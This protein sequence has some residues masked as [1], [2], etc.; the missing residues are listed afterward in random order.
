MHGV[1]LVAR[2]GPG[3]AQFLERAAEAL[4]VR[5]VVDELA[6]DH[7]A[8]FVDPVGEQEAAV[9]YRDFPFGFREI[10]AIHEDGADH[11]RR[12]L[13][14]CTASKHDSGRQIHGGCGRLAGR[15]GEWPTSTARQDIMPRN[16]PEQAIKAMLSR[17]EALF[18]QRNPISKK[19]SEDAARNWLKGVP[20]HW[21]VDWGTPVP[22]VH[23]QGA[24]RRRDRRRRPPLHRLLPGRHRRHV[25][26]FAARRGR[27]AAARGR[28]RL[29]HHDA[30]A[31]C[32]RR[33]PA[34]GR[35]L[36][37]ALLAGDGDGVRRQPRRHQVVPRHHRPQEDPGLQ[38]LLPW[39]GGRDLR[40]HRRRHAPCRPRADRRG[41]RP[42][43]VHQGRRVQRHPGARE[44]AGRRATSPACWPSRS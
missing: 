43:A 22:A 29:H 24:G 42:D 12:L 36:R 9:E 10:L 4:H 30:L 2:A 5:G 38:P 1:Q 40:D 26:P 31:R 14:C 25:R 37:P 23:R 41:A 28:Q 8:H 15:L 17:E 3:H 20:M 34:A 13:R 19:L 27:G 11:G 7:G 21:M 39:R 33:G 32:G 18:T 35:P 16:I 44:G 6:V